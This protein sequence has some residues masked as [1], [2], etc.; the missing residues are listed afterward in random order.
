MKSI[1]FHELGFEELKMKAQ[2]GD[3]FFVSIYPEYVNEIIHPYAVF[4]MDNEERDTERKY[5][6]CMISTNMKKAYWPG[7]IVLNENEGNLSKRSIL[8]CSKTIF[9]REYQFKEYVGR[10]NE[11]R[12]NEIIQSIKKIDEQIEKRRMRSIK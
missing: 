2:I 5:R 8:I 4:E 1:A 12:I 7:N 6:M 9:A 3:I 10:L 11:N